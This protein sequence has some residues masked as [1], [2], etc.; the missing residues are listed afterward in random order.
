MKTRFIIIALMIL[1]GGSQPVLANGNRVG[2]G[3]DVVLCPKSG[4]LLDFYE[5]SGAIRGFSDEK[6]RE[7]ILEQVFKNLERLS[8][9]QAR[10]YKAR[11][12]EFISE[13][14]FKKEIALENIE[15]SNHLFGPKDK[16]CSL[17]QIAIRRHEA[18]LDGKRFLVDEELWN[19]LSPRGQAGLILHEVVYEHLYKL[20]EEDSVRARKLNAYYFSNKAFA[21][22]QDSYWRLVKDLNLPIYR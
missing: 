16:K 2:N 4:E 12:A 19:R 20:G 22:S 10:Q 11:A 5:N 21:D 1:C 14:E 6:S 9:K 8:P 3:G 15:D 17:Q 7:A 13:T 18:G